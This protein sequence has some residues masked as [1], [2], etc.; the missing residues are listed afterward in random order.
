MCP[1]RSTVVVSRHTSSRYGPCASRA[2]QRW[3]AHSEP[4]SIGGTSCEE[5]RWR[6]GT[7]SAEA[8]TCRYRMVA[9]PATYATD[10]QPKKAALLST[11]LK[12]EGH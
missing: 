2:P 7:F 3:H 12:H 10:A 4:S 6:Q 1:N 9:W 11:S 8:R 5:R